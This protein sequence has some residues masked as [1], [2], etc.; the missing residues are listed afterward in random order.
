MERNTII[1]GEKIYT[2]IQEH[3]SL[4]DHK[5]GVDRYDIVSQ[6]PP[7]TFPA[8]SRSGVS[9]LASSSILKPLRSE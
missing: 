5:V 7:H 9:W 4:T 8:L 2:A 1:S 6:P 3:G